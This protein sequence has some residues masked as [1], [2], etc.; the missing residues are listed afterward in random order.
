[1]EK[2]KKKFFMMLLILI[3]A[4]TLVALGLTAIFRPE[5]FTSIINP[6]PTTEY[7]SVNV[8]VAKQLVLQ[9]VTCIDVRGLEGCGPCQFNQGHL[10]NAITYT[11]PADLYNVSSDILVYSMDGTVGEQFCKDLMG[12]VYGKVYNLQGGWYA[13]SNYFEPTRYT[14]SPSNTTET[15]NWTEWS[16]VWCIIF[17]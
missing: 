6:K 10:P 17:R 2:K 8:S 12:H 13:W 1:M 11:L 15:T 4:L 16:N 14:L 9:N 3:V 5:T 7:Q